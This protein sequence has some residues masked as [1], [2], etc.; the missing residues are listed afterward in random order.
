[1]KGRPFA[2]LVAVLPIAAAGLLTMNAIVSVR[3]QVAVGEFCDA[4]HE[5]RPDVALLRSQELFTPD[6]N[7]LMAAQCRCD[8]LSALGR[9]GECA[10]LFDDLLTRAG[11]GAW[12]PE[13]RL[14][15]LIARLRLDSGRPSEALELVRHVAVSNPFDLELIDLELRARSGVEGERQALAGV[16][17]A[18]DDSPASL[19]HRVGLAMQRRRMGDH[20]NAL[21][22]LGS[23]LPPRD[24]PLLAPWFVERAAALAALE[25][26]VEVKQTYRD[27]QNLGGDPLELRARYALRLSRSGLF[28]PEHPWPE[29]LAA[30]IS[31]QERAGQRPFQADLYERLISHLLVEQRRDEALRVFD[32]ASQRYE[33]ATISRA[34]IERGR[35]ALAAGSEGVGVIEFRLPSDAAGMLLWVSAHGHGPPDA[36][37]EP[38]ALAAS[39]SRPEGKGA[40]SDAEGSFSVRV[41]RKVSAWP[42]RWV[43]R[44]EERHVHASGAAWVT[45][46]SVVRI[47]VEPDPS[48]RFAPTEMPAMEVPA[49]DGR[50]R[51]V[52]L[53]LDCG[54]WRLVQYLRTRGEL[55]VLDHWFT[56]GHRAVLTS[57]PPLTAAAMEALVWPDRGQAPSML[58]LVHRMGLE[59]AG[60]ASVGENPLQ[61]LT[62]LLPEGETLFEV[63]GA[64][65]RV[66]ANMLFS[67][68]RIRGGRH[69]EVIGPQGR[70]A[71]TRAAA[72]YRPLDVQERARF[73]SL[74]E[75]TRVRGRIESIASEL[76]AAVDFA[77]AG[78][79]D[80]LLLRLESLDILTH[81]FYGELTSQRQD[82]GAGVL[83]DVYRYIDGR[84]PEVR[85]AL[86]ADDVL[87]VMS[88]HGIKTAMEHAPDALFVAV[89]GGVPQGRAPGSPSLAGVA[90]V[91]ASLVGVETAWPDSGV[92]SWATSPER[93][94]LARGAPH[95]GDAVSVRP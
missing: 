46:G 48:P 94:A 62:A 70:R 30:T 89:G 45:A 5:G 40:A 91:L 92:A 64:G 71:S 52:V 56:S 8:A 17:R 26:L 16:E 11:L 34:Q 69:A 38:I 65:D 81:A 39:E 50:R 24:H 75:D 79:V 83:L 12:R 57:D 43:L 58:G 18:L 85:Q 77:A 51:V 4:V 63:V 59:L 84:L 15:A 25:R 53:L 13:P 10:A 19:R 86:D 82:D 3:Q 27:W 73:P 32:Q 67:H 95:P 21:R 60:L 33:L 29:L 28:D 14:A 2:T 74:T 1:M 7:G 37:Y 23:T 42:E 93:L 44:D 36:S 88:D 35:A 49:G 41:E 90:R 66:A 9:A 72:A 55:P 54:D 87:I 76:D 78:D 22:A 20:A 61:F 31:E 80:L 47:D 68:G 6:A